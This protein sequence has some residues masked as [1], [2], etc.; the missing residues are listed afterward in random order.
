M[1]SQ[2]E[3]PV[4]FNPGEGHQASPAGMSVSLTVEPVEHEDG[5][6]PE[7]A[8]AAVKT[9]LEACSVGRRRGWLR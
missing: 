1:R 6:L 9:E 4:F 3:G 2:A 8:N 7:L 5:L